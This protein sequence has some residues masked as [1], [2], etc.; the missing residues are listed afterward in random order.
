MYDD[1]TQ[2]ELEGETSEVKEE[3]EEEG[4]D[5]FQEDEEDDAS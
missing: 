4:A 5:D 2:S 3:P 1:M